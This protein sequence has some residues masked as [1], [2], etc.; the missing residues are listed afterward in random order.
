MLKYTITKS[1][2]NNGT[3]DKWYGRIVY[4]ETIDMDGLAEHMRQHNIP[5][6]KGQLKGVMADLVRCIY[7][8]TTAGKKVKLPDLGIFRIKARGKGAKTK[9]DCTI[10]ECLLGNNL[11][12]RPSGAMRTKTWG[13]ER[14]RWDVKWKRVERV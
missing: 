14:N 3:K 8:L 9:D 13:D 1:D 12:F 11:S 10:T 2:A 6:T 5:Y 7:E 4:D